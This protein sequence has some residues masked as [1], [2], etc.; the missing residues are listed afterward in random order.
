MFG[1]SLIFSVLAI[2]Y[3]LYLF[4]NSVLA[5]H[6]V[7]YLLKTNF[8]LSFPLCLVSL[9]NFSVLA[10]H[11]VWYLLRKFSVLAIH[12]VWY[13]LKY[14]FRR[15]SYIVFASHCPVSKNSHRRWYM[16]GSRSSSAASWT[17]RAKHVD[18]LAEVSTS[19][20]IG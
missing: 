11:Y 6:Y 8:S 20:C 9:K 4:K 19:F 2:H 16:S 14:Y 7:W 3:V 13:L 5:I 17:T 18:E 15:A 12:Y 10:I 1:I